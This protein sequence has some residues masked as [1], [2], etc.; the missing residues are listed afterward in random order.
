[1]KVQLV[2]VQGKPEGKIIPL[3]GPVFKIGR[4][5][6]C[7]LRPNSELVSRE[8]AEFTIGADSVVVKDLG[9]RNGTLVN[10]KVLTA[11]HQL[12]DRDL[13]QVGNLTFAISIQGVPVVAAKAPTRE[14]AVQAARAPRGGGQETVRLRRRERRDRIL[15]G[16][17]G[18]QAQV[19]RLLGRLRGRDGL[20]QH[21]QDSPRAPRRPPAAPPPPA[22]APASTGDDDEFY[23][24]LPE[25]EG[26]PET[27]LEPDNETEDGGMIPEEFLDESNP[28]YVKKKTEAESKPTYKDTS[29]AASDILKKMMERRRKPS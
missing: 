23:E 10:G 1:M 19:R 6:T 25:G 24:R 20:H 11:S 12:K 26:D 22:S 4:G 28:F 3:L 21:D 8:H 17:R 2:V 15:A 16:R 18:R 13:V 14:G 7:H 9:S 27:G 29:D 5:E